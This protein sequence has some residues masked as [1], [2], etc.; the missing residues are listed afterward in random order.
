MGHLKFLSKFAKVIVNVISQHC[1]HLVRP[2]KN[3]PVTR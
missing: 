1:C 3:R 2:E